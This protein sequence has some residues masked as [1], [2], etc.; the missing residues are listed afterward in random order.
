MVEGLKSDNLEHPEQYGVRDRN[1]ADRWEVYRYMRKPIEFSDVLDPLGLEGDEVILDVGCGDGQWLMH[2][3]QERVHTGRL[4]GMDIY[5][6]RLSETMYEFE[7]SEVENVDFVTGRAEDLPFAEDSI[8]VALCLFMLYHAEDR[9]AALDELK[10]VVKP[11]GLIVVSTSGGNNKLRHRE[12]ER[13]IAEFLKVDPPP[14]FSSRFTA[15]MAEGI[16]PEW[17]DVLGRVPNTEEQD[18]I[19]VQSGPGLDAYRKS[20]QSM[21]QS[22]NP[23]I[24]SKR[25]RWAL[26]KEVMP[27][28]EEEVDALG[29]FLDPASRV[30]FICRNRK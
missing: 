8:D 3:A 9:S 23:P 1:L 6:D 20:L 30:F 14:V 15:E 12:F 17:F 21:N 13:R 2:L 5:S 29:E 22:Y 26:K 10:R 24:N 4:I 16:L 7:M 28:I 27:E 11:D 18:Y 25:W 19:C